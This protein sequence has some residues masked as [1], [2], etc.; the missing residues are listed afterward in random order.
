MFDQLLISETEGTREKGR[1]GYFAVSGIA[2]VTLLVTA[3]VYSIFAV[4]FRIASSGFEVTQML[5][6]VM[7]PAAEPIPE[8]QPQPRQNMASTPQRS[9]TNVPTRA[10]NMARVD[11][12]RYV[13]KEVSTTPN[14]TLS[15]PLGDVKF[16]G[17]DTNPV[18]PGTA[19]RDTGTGTG[20]LGGTGTGPATNTVA[21]ADDP[22]PPP[23]VKRDPPPTPAP[24]KQISGGVVNGKAISLP[25]PTY[26]AAAVAVGASGRVDVQVLIDERGNVISAKAVSGH[27]LLRAS[28]EQAARNARFE[29]TKLSDVP[30]KVSGVIIYNFTQS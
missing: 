16:T 2:M 27:P 29:A 12:T 9:E 7:P 1:R 19:G 4:D 22:P 24:P 25:K 28:A 17:R 6:P 26:S 21:V 10:V 20:S 13:P 18:D 15:R 23:P 8:P 11:E 14:T 3:L 5:L 30:V